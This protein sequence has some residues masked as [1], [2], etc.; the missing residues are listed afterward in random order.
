MAARYTP[1]QKAVI[2]KMLEGS[3]V[4]AVAKETGVSRM[5]ISKWKTEA[6]LTA[7]EIEAKKGA[8]A[9]GRK[10]KATVEK[11]AKSAGRKAKK[12]AE[13]TAETVKAAAA[14]AADEAKDAIDAAK[15][16]GKKNARKAGRKVKETVG[17]IASSDV[18][19]AAQVEAGK[20]KAK[21]TR[22]AEEVK[23][24]IQEKKAKSP[25]N[26]ARAAKINMVF[27]SA[28]GGA[29]TTD[30]IAKKLPAGTTDAYIKIE[31]NMIYYVLKSGE[32]GSLEIWE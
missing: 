15:I 29:I 12:A 24:A 4:A 19:V 3:S 16:E 23:E 6:D 26:K 25:V 20:A 14:V 21:R 22:K 18:A 10:A 11:T 9:A 27:Q 30:E 7:A 2:L 17:Q 31:E 8:R 28:M 1:E 13:D 32:T 5:T